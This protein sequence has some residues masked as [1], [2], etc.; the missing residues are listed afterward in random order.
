MKIRVCRSFAAYKKG[1]EF[2]WSRGMCRLLIARGLIEEIVQPAEGETGDVLEQAE[3][4]PVVE[5]AVVKKK[6]KPK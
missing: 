6:R 3:F 5:Q 4:Q 2:D 1:Q